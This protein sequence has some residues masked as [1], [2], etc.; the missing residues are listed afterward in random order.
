MTYAAGLDAATIVWIADR[1]TDEH[2]AA[3]DWL[4]ELTADEF[5]FFGLEIEAW[6]IGESAVAPKF[7]VV[8][9]PNEWSADIRGTA[10]SGG[11]LSDTKKLQLEYWTGLREILDESNSHIRDTKPRPQ[12]WT[13]AFLESSSNAWQCSSL[14]FAGRDSGKGTWCMPTVSRASCFFNVPQVVRWKC[15]QVDASC[16]QTVALSLNSTLDRTFARRCE[17]CSTIRLE[18][19]SSMK[20]AESVREVL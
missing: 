14:Y 7:N 5:H 2:R 16:S 11:E 6:K 19:F 8:S 17:G 15:W 1:F 18:N 12:H 4:N 13:K 3:M 10:R 9:K 20:P